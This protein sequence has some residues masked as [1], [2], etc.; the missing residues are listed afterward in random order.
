VVPQILPDGR[1][2]LTAFSGVFQIK[3]DIPFL[4][5]VTLDGNSYKIEPDFAQY[6]NQYDCAAVPLYSSTAN[7]MHT[8]FFGGIAQYTTHDGLLIQDKDVPFVKTISRV[9]R[10]RHGVM[11]EY[12]LP[13]EMPALLGASSEFIP[14]AEIPKYENGVIKLDELNS[15]S[16]L[17]GYMYG[18]IESSAPNIF[19][20]NE[21]TESKA[22]PLLYK[23][24][25]LKGNS[26]KMHLLNPQSNNGYQLQIYPDPLAE[27][28]FMSFTLK[29][30]SNV[31][32]TVSNA[33]GKEIL[34][35]DLSN[36][37]QSGY[38]RIEKKIKPFK[39]GDTYSF[40][41]KFPSGV[42]TQQV[43][44]KE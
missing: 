44:V 2:A 5:S 24:L 41:L 14:V 30:K 39:I 21:G 34:N 17:I 1:S 16:T 7:E 18:G 19:W 35:E 33:K 12:K 26:S 28:F 37:V 29:E 3:A 31:H 42:F 36:Q 6:Y 27:T 9:T 15:D 23:I 13:V 40:S 22:Q 32:L 4:N 25:L 8:L 11:S 20:I 43:L 38:N 10:D